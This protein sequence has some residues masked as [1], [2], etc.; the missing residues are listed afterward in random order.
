M[1]TLVLVDHEA[2]AIKDATLATV[3]AASQLGEVHLLVAGSNVGAVAEAAAE[4]VLANDETGAQTEAHQTRMMEEV[5]KLT[6]GSDGTLDE[7]DYQR[8]VDTLLSGGSTR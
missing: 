8:T 1:K 2:G 3:T 5:A 6:A 7:A 4:I